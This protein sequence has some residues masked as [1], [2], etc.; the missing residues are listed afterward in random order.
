M[1]LIW[2]NAFS[3]T[4]NPVETHYRLNVC[5]RQNQNIWWIFQIFKMYLRKFPNVK[6]VYI[7]YKKLNIFWENTV[8]KSIKLSNFSLMHD[9][10][11][12]TKLWNLAKYNIAE[13]SDEIIQ[14]D[15]RAELILSKLPCLV[16]KNARRIPLFV[17][18]NVPTLSV[19]NLYITF[20]LFISIITPICN[21]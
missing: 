20:I 15:V 11:L 14:I 12:N 3:R 19:S 5:Y 13:S 7:K 18:P 2:Y 4:Y 8:Y 6:N 10:I 21:P 9:N 17:W 16:F 1:R